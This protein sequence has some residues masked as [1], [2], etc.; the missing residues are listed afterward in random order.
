M[1]SLEYTRQERAIKNMD[2]FETIMRYL[3][4]MDFFFDGVK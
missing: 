3:K 4:N 1:A 2:T